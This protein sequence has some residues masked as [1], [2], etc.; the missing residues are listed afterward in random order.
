MKIENLPFFSVSPIRTFL[1]N[2]SKNAEKLACWGMTCSHDLLISALHVN[3]SKAVCTQKGSTDKEIIPKKCRETMQ[4]PTKPRRPQSKNH[5]SQSHWNDHMCVSR[6]WTLT[7]QAAA[8]PSLSS[9][10][11]LPSSHAPRRHRAL[12]MHF[13]DPWK[14]MQKL[15]GRTKI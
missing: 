12:S 8:L 7:N 1:L 9:L 14:L 6:N 15:K 4:T 10:S 5:N 11:L 3:S 13:H 2:V